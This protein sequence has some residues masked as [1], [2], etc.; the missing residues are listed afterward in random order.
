MANVVVFLFVCVIIQKNGGR[1]PL[2]YQSF[3]KLAGEPPAPLTETYSELPPV[4]NV[5]GYELLS[6]PTIEEFGYGDLSQV[7]SFCAAW[8]KHLLLV[9][10]VH[11]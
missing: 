6:V 5:E 11:Y 9:M 3:V 1:P 10:L 4:G 7:C 8:S 2:T